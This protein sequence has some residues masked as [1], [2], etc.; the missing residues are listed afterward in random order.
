MS[1]T[2]PILLLIAGR[3]KLRNVI[4]TFLNTFLQIALSRHCGIVYKIYAKCQRRRFREHSTP[5]A[6]NVIALWEVSLSVYKN[7]IEWRR[8]A[9]SQSVC[10]CNQCYRIWLQPAVVQPF[11]FWKMCRQ[12][13]QDCRLSSNKHPVMPLHHFCFLSFALNVSWDMKGCADLPQQLSK[14]FLSSVY[15]PVFMYLFIYA[16]SA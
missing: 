1:F 5:I 8:L 12:A 11:W 10:V 9:I 2:V 16:L 6:C 13:R 15:I 3:V 4:K 14:S 7:S